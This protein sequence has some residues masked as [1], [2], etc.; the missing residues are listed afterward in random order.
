MLNSQGPISASVEN[1]NNASRKSSANTTP[2]NV[3]ATAAVTSYV[4]Q[5]KKSVK[6][7]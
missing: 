2:N 1:N 4:N 7:K 3:L 5:S 6:S